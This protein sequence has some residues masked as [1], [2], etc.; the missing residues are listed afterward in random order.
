MT[1]ANIWCKFVIRSEPINSLLSDR[2]QRGLLWDQTSKW[3]HIKA[4]FLQGSILG[5]LLFLVYI[6]DL[7]EGLTLQ[8]S[9]FLLAILRYSRWF[10]IQVLHRYLLM[11]TYPKHRNGGANGRCYLILMLQ[12]KPKRLFS[13]AKKSF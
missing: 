7:P 8:M 1:L 5:P 6:N 13:H 9:N 2:S 4:G 10:V 12:N 3:S 11:R